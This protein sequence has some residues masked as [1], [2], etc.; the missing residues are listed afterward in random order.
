[1][2]AHAAAHAQCLDAFVRA[3]ARAR[4]RMC[5]GA[6]Q[7]GLLGVRAPERSRP[8]SHPASAPLLRLQGGT[9]HNR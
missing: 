7:F 1:M 5:H 8:A 9:R 6:G 3:R 2:H 4:L